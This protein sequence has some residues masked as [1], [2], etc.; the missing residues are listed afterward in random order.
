MGKSHWR[1]R[2]TPA[3]GSLSKQNP[4]PIVRPRNIV[5][6]PRWSTSFVLAS[7]RD[8][9]TAMVPRSD[10]VPTGSPQATRIPEW[11]KWIHP[12]LRLW[13]NALIVVARIRGFHVGNCHPKAG[14]RYGVWEARWAH[15]YLSANAEQDEEQWREIWDEVHDIEEEIGNIVRQ[16]ARKGFARGGK[17]GAS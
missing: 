10:S 11:F 17:G 2:I 13:Q 9:G 8:E 15:A 16:L 7:D 1:V 12:D 14:E 3:D 6:V 5:D 4:L